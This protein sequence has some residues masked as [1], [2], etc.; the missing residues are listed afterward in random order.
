MGG[1]MGGGGMNLAGTSVMGST[2]KGTGADRS[3]SRGRVGNKAPASNPFSSSIKQQQAPIKGTNSAAAFQS[4][5]KAQT[6]IKTNDPGKINAKDFG[7][8]P[9]ERKRSTSNKRS[10]KIAGSTKGMG[11]NY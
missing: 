11:F 6:P 1:G 2:S 7:R 5:G 4:A 8:M 10:T 9:E 3:N